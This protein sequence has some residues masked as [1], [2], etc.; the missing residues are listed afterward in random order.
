MAVYYV[1]FVNHNLL[2]KR[3]P[4]LRL[5]GHFEIIL[6]LN[7]V[8]EKNVK[9]YGICKGNAV[10]RSSGSCSLRNRADRMLQRNNPWTE[11]NISLR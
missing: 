11:L 4:C 3:L 6:C 5:L 2:H 7:L 9:A 10:M 8:T 1:I